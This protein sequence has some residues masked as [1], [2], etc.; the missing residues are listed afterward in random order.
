MNDFGVVIPDYVAPIVAPT[1][2]DNKK[3]EEYL[4][5]KNIIE[6]WCKSAVQKILLQ[7][8]YQAYTTNQDLMS[9]LREIRK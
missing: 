7:N 9:V 3:F 8:L 5:I 1:Y 2:Q 4:L 6:E